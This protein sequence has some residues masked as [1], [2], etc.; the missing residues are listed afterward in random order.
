MTLK[1]FTALILVATVL[2]ALTL[3]ILPAQ[4]LQVPNNPADLRVALIDLRNAVQA[5]PAEARLQRLVSAAQWLEGNSSNTA[6]ATVSE[7]YVRSIRRAAELLSRER[8]AEVIEDVTSDLEAKV[9]HCRS[10]GLSMGGS[11]NLKVS[12]VRGPGAV[13]DWQIFYL[14]KIYER[15]DGIPPGNFPR[16]SSPTDM[17]LEP[18]RY[19][20]W[21]RNP[22][23]G[24][25]SERA[26]VRVA[27]QK[28]ILLDLPV[29]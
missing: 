11:V 27:G 20:V 3:E 25:V 16:L 13:K 6:S 8:T 9:D 14:L 26:L 28:E 7:E 12:T 18:G 2:P 5:L 29:P 24:S 15:A 22:S 4:A 1:R 17:Q 23:T 21:A 10:L 19:W